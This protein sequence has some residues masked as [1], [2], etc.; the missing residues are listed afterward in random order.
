MFEITSDDIARLSDEQLR[1]LVGLLCEAELRSRGYSSAA[2][3]WGGNQN[4]ADG[5]LDV[6]VK[7]PNDKPIDGFVPRPATGFQVKKQDMPPSAIALEM[8][9]KGVPRP[10]IQE[11]ADSGGAYIIASSEGSTADIA[12][13]RRRE[14]MAEATSDLAN[15]NQL[16]LDFYDRTRLASWVRTHAGLIVWVRQVIGRAIPGWEPFDAWA[17]PAGGTEAEYLLDE[18]VRICARPAKS[19][20]DLPTAVG[21]DKIREILRQPRSVVRLVGLS[22]VG[23]TRFVQALFDNRIGEGSLDPSQV[24]YTNMNNA[25]DPQ[26]VGLASDLIANGIR[27]IVI[28]DNCSSELHTRLSYIVKKTPSTLSVLTVEFDIRE[29]Q[30]EGTEVFEVEVASTDL[31]EKLLRTRFPDLSQVDART[32]AEFSGGNARIAIA[33]AGTVGRSG[34]LGCLNDDQLF[35]RLFVQRQDQ[36]KPLL[37]IAQ[38]CSLVY[39]FNGKD[40]TDAED[41]ELMKLAKLVGATV[42]D[43]YRA[44]AEL[45]RRDLAQQRGVWRAILPHAIANRLAAI[46]LQNVPYARIEN[47]LINGA[48]ERLAKSFSRRLG[49]LHTS[50]EAAEIVR[51][52]LNKDGWLGDVWNL[53]EFGEAIFQNILPTD[54]EAALGAIEAGLPA[55]N[56]STP[57]IAGRYIPRALRSIAYDAALFD[58]CVAVLQTLAIFGEES[59]SEEASE[60]HKSLF[61]IYLSGTHASVERRAAVVKKLLVSVKPRARALGS[62]ALD[63][64]LEAMHFNSH[65][66]FQFGAH[67]RDYGYQPKTYEDMT[68]WY[69]TGLALAEENALSD[70]PVAAVAK[71]QISENFRGLWSRVGLRDE[72]ETLFMMLAAKG[73]WREGWLAVKLTRHYDEKD[74]ASKNYARLSKLEEALRPVDLV[75]R[76]RGRVLSANGSHYDVDD[77]EVG[78]ADTYR[79]AT[80]KKEAEVEALGEEVASDPSAFRELLPEIV[81]GPGNLWPFGKGLAKGTEHPKALWQELSQ[82]F[83]I[84][85]QQTRNLKVFRGILWEWNA[86]KPELV[87]ELLDDALE[88]EP[89]AAYFPDLQSAVILDQRG[90]DRLIRSLALG[91]VAT[92]R[93]DNLAFGGATDNAP[94]ADLASF[95]LALANVPD[96]VSVAVR[97]LS[98]DFFGDEQYK[99]EHAPE[100]VAAGRAL[101]ELIKFNRKNQLDDFD[102]DGVVSACLTDDDG[103]AVAKVICENLKQAVVAHDTYVFDHNQLLRRLFQKQPT[104]VLDEFFTGDEKA[105]ALGSRIIEEAST[106]QQNPTDQVSDA[107]L[108]AWCERNPIARFPAI[109]LAVSCFGVLA[110]YIPSSWNHRASVLVHS[111]PDPI[112][113]M[114]AFAARLRPSV[115]RGSRSTILE[116]NAKFL[117]QFDIHGNA[118]LAA[119]IETEKASLLREAAADREWETK[120]DKGRDERF[121]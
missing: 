12:L 17:Y 45:L 61:Y 4:A 82:Q 53:N 7:M 30:P 73:F 84:T 65:Y 32:A 52:W 54:P 47:S 34:A 119:F 41:G 100:L 2:V 89:L 87:N 81:S 116:T 18:G 48:S 85:A 111:A 69:R 99:R 8:R 90:M 86:S 6:L 24:I 46:A 26:P 95:I 15:A 117:E 78:S 83:A 93:Y 3:T 33:L 19:D 11:L 66:D 60:M 67:S 68:H 115:L 64:M 106:H 42:D 107:T 25:P 74:N 51:K 101:L 62:K 9:P 57:I 120:Y 91:K 55:H 44:V 43:V 16:M 35:Q 14:A 63:A 108:L 23:K 97:I 1:T 88:N 105:I 92:H 71:V 94:G 102:L 70:S 10:V 76:V 121:E 31:I 36:D 56:A 21:I 118:K 77:V 39:S 59:I 29:D 28:V 103:Y 72:L 104:A 98:M 20:G 79:V 109:A 13:A 49:Y 27:A 38:A 112:A 110:D 96:G 80:E 37:E 75:Q 40:L 113:V 58:R 22:G 5:G 114:R 50:K